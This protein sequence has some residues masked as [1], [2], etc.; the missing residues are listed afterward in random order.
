MTIRLY[1]CMV[2]R[3]QSGDEKWV[4][5]TNGEGRYVQSLPPAIYTVEARKLGYETTTEQEIIVTDG[6][7]IGLDFILEKKQETQTDIIDSNI[8]EDAE[9]SHN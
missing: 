4:T 9:G 5:Y 7:A 8:V 3:C 6:K 2:F 1:P